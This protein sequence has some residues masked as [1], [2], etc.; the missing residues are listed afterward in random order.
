MSL[1]P[2]A[3]PAG[4]TDEPKCNAELGNGKGVR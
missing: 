2:Q 4:L 1:G 3:D